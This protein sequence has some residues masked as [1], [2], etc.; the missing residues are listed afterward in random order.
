MTEADQRAPGPPYL[1]NAVTNRR[2]LGVTVIS[3]ASTALAEMVVHDQWTPHLGEQIL[4]GLRLCL[5]GPSASIIVDLRH[6]DDP[7]GISLPFWLAAWRQARLG[8]APVP[9]VFC[10]PTTAALSRRLRSIEG[11]QPRVFST[12]PEARI[13]IAE[14]LSRADRLQTRLPPEP[15]A[16]RAARE[17]AARA[18]H[19]WQLPH[20]L[21]D[22]SL[23]VSELVTNAVEHACTDI[24]VTLVR[25][26]PRLHIAVHDRDTRFPHP[27]GPVAAGATRGLGLLLVSRIAAGW[28]AMPTRG[29]KVVWATVT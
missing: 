4:A 22:T 28:G 29:G 21:A 26:G 25:A 18:C 8:P 2:G 13:R 10:L 19:G 27:P 20:L 5:A 23:I 17:L 24:V 12:V 14:R 11:P 7:Y 6:L 1:L 15:A 16:I 3:D 9:L